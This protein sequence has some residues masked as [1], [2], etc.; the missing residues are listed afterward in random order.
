MPPDD[1]GGNGPPKRERPALAGTG[2]FKNNSNKTVPCTTYDAN[3][4]WEAEAALWRAIDHAIISAARSR[5]RR[6]ACAD[7]L[8]TIARRAN[9]RLQRLQARL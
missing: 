5:A 8:V 9:N 7:Q 6:A 3:A 4:L 1:R 2:A